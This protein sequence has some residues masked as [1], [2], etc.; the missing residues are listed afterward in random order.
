MIKFRLD[1]IVNDGD[2]HVV[3]VHVYDDA[4][5]EILET[6][7]LV[8][9]DREDFKYR[10]R[11]KTDALKADYDAKKAREAEVKQALQ[12]LKMEVK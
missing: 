7:S 8:W 10:L 3:Y 1:K 2:G 6:A 4:T 5:D 11:N 9:K 12:E